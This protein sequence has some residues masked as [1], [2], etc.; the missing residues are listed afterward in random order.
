MQSTGNFYIA[1]DH[2]GAPH[3]I[4]NATKQVVWLWDH[5]PFGNG[6]PT[7]NLTYNLRLPGQ[8]YDAETGLNYNY[9][10]DYDPQLGRYIQSDPIRLNGGINTYAY[11]P[12]STFNGLDQYGLAPQIPGLGWASSPLLSKW[13]QDLGFDPQT[14]QGYGNATGALIDELVSGPQCGIGKWIMATGKATLQLVKSDVDAYRGLIDALNNNVKSDEIFF[15]QAGK[16]A[17]QIRKQREQQQCP[18]KD[19]RPPAQSCTKQKPPPVSNQ[20]KTSNGPRV[21]GPLQG[22][23]HGPIEPSPWKVDVWLGNQ[24]QQVSFPAR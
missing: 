7:G 17:D 11:V 8:Y 4:T 13:Y 22:P 10:R 20:P 16:R 15:E 24:L 14:A 1:P 18:K 23:I 3:Q 12:G 2:L 19:N 5:D 21:P 9:Y 6:A